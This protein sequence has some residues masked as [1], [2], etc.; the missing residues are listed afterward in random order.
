MSCSLDKIKCQ[1]LG[2]LNYLECYDLQL[3]KHA[4]VAHGNSD[5]CILMVEHDN[6]L[7][8]GKHGKE[9]NIKYDPEYL[10]AKNRP[11]HRVERGGDVTAHMPGQLV[12]YP[13]VHLGELGWGVRKYV[14]ILEESL[15][16]FLATFGIRGESNDVVPG[17]G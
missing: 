6:V 13:I 8:L 7:T 10:R 2:R 12:V 16:K 17:S 5:G 15:L 11:V 3:Q 4:K 14:Q 9:S 1:Y